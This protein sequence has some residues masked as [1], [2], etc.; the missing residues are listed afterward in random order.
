MPY[1]CTGASS[2]FK[3]NYQIILIRFVQFNFFFRWFCCCHLFVCSIFV[4]HLRLQ[5]ALT[6]AFTYSEISIVHLWPLS[7]SL[8]MNLC[9]TV[10]FAHCTN[11]ISRQSRGYSFQFQ[12]TIAYNKLNK[13]NKMSNCRWNKNEW[14]KRNRICWATNEVI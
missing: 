12:F 9:T 2:L 8:T 11:V 6:C 13:W 4:P 14:E 10:H 1:A 7:L 3:Q 5:W